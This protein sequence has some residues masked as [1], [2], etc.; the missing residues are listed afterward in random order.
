MAQRRGAIAALDQ[1][2]AQYKQTVLT[3]F[4]NVADTLTALELDAHQLQIQTDAEKAA[5][6]TLKLTEAQYRMGAVGYL[7]LLDAERQFHLAR[8]GR[9]QAEALR[10]AD[11]ASLFQALGGGWWNRQMME[12]KI[13]TKKGE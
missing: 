10:Y 1:A 6:Q 7:N 2:V 12:C 4:Q 8:I 9:I 5:T 11:T 13:V 3:A